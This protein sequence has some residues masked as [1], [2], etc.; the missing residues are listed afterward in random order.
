MMFLLMETIGVILIY[1]MLDSVEA[2]ASIRSNT[3]VSTPASSI[4]PDE[5]IVTKC[6][7]GVHEVFNTL[8]L[9]S[10]CVFLLLKL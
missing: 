7:C 3:R 6:L 2:V 8:F 9:E 1:F 10:R 4:V 5:D